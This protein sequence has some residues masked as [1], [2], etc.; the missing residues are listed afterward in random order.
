[1]A[2]KK[3]RTDKFSKEW[4]YACECWTALGVGSTVPPIPNYNIYESTEGTTT[5]E[6]LIGQKPINPKSVTRN[7]IN[8]YG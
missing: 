5:K 8:V 7:G 2:E 6:R 3:I 4:H 1:M